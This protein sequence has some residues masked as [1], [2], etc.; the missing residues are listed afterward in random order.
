LLEQIIKSII[1]YTEQK[2]YMEIIEIIKN[3]KVENEFKELVKVRNQK[4]KLK[5]KFK[6]YEKIIIEKIKNNEGIEIG[7]TLLRTNS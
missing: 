1:E 7:L 5:N 3:F 6:F 4:Y 2:E